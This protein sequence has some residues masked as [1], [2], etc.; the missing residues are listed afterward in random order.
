[1]KIAV[2]IKQTP[3]TAELPKIAA[4][5]VRSGSVKT[6]MVINPWDEFAAEEAILLSERLNAEAV[7]ISLGPS[8]AVDALKHAVAMGV[9]A[10]VLVDN[11]GLEGAD[12]WA[13]A[14]ALA[15]AVQAQGEVEIVLTGR[16]SVDDN[17][18]ALFAGVAS[19]LGYRL[20]TNVSKI[21]DVANNAVIVERQ[22]EGAQ[23]TVKAPLPVVISVAKEINEPRYPSFMGI[24]RANRAAI[25]TLSLAD[26][27]LGDLASKTQWTNIRKPEVRR[28]QVQIIDGATVQEKAQKLV[29]ALLTE[30]V[31]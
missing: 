8:D 23:E 12:L 21:V 22:V 24:R 5:D 2:L 3:D 10:A 7:A 1:M 9:P 18:G 25:P 19:R 11:T 31:I 6:T 26:L 14:T 30:K 27:G 20:L 15:A 16:Q 4:D 28:T 29:D 17:S 13:T